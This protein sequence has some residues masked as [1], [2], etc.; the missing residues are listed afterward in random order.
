MIVPMPI[1]RETGA[2]YPPLF[3]RDGFV[4][5]NAEQAS[6][7]VWF[8]DLAIASGCL[9]RR[10]AVKSVGVP[11]AVDSFHGCLTFEYCLRLRR[12]GYKIAVISSAEMAHEIGNSRRVNLPGYKRVWMN[13]PPWREYYITRNLTYL[14]WRLY[15]N[16][17]TKMSMARYLAVHFA[18]VLLFST[19]KLACAAR[20]IQGFVDGF[21]GRLGIRL[22][23]G[24]G[25]FR[26]RTVALA[27]TEKIEAGKA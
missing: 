3:W 23:P 14:A 17:S 12:C 5:S 7:P 19:N 26:K 27:P 8:A 15:P 13:Q 22:R 21:R 25:E 11:R 2:K 1:N 20:I 16:F 4:K 10:E 24:V 9:V 6:R 18:G